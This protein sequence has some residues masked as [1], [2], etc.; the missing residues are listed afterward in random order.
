MKMTNTVCVRER[1]RERERERTTTTTTTNKQGEGGKK[2]ALRKHTPKLSCN[3]YLG[4]SG[5][6]AGNRANTGW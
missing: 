1:E 3:R 6:T 2:N 4:Y 5:T